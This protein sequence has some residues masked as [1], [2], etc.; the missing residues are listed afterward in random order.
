MP[1]D[2]QQLSPA[3]AIQVLEKLV[4]VALRVKPGLW[5]YAHHGNEL[6]G[7]DRDKLALDHGEE[8][9][10]VSPDGP[11]QRLADPFSRLWRRLQCHPIHHGVVQASALHEED[12]RGLVAS[13]KDNLPLC[14]R[15]LVE[16][17]TAEP[18]HHHL[19]LRIEVVEERML[20]E[21][22]R[23]H[24]VRQLVLQRL[25]KPVQDL[26]LAQLHVVV[27]LAVLVLKVLVDTAG[28]VL[29]DVPLP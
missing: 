8:V 16:C 17:K 29:G 7:I 3:D 27:L 22:R 25:R 28:K 26:D 6:V 21:V 13:A 5:V 19:H 24:L 4:G 15:L 12:F 1:E 18:V 23:V 9:A 20:E 14:V 10:L 2:V 11:K